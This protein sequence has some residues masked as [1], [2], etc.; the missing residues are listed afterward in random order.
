M[1]EWVKA[2]EDKTFGFCSVVVVYRLCVPSAVAYDY[3]VGAGGGVAGG[4]VGDSE[5]KIESCAS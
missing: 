1:L 5:K 3:I 4:A 2:D